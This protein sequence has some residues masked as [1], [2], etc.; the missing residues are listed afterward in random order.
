MPVTLQDIA[1]R[2]GVSVPTVSRALAGYSDIAE[3]TRARVVQA[4]EEMG[5]RPN[6]IARRLQQQR[7]ETVGFIIPTHG[8]R[9]SD[10][11][12]SELLAGIGNE[13]AEQ[14]YDLL[15]STQ[16][17]EGEEL[18]TYERMVMEQRV[19]GMLVVRTRR[20]DRRIAYLLEQEFPFVAFGRSDLDASFPYLDVDGREGM[21]Q[22][23]QHLI[24]Q[25][26][27]HIAYIGPPIH[28][29]FASHRLAGYREA[30]TANGIPFDESLVLAGE[31]TERSGHEA[32]T[33]LLAR[34]PRPDAVVACNDL[35]A[36]GT[37]SAA[38]RLGLA[39][40]HDLA[41]TGFD[42]VPLAAH[43]HPPLTTVRQPIYAIGRQICRTLI[44]L[45]RDEL[46]EHQQVVLEP[47]LIIRAS[48]T[49]V[50]ATHEGGDGHR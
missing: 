17:P 49:G 9:F 43:A 47:E 28:V 3:E 5:Y 11:F 42:D 18:K 14:E 37:I 7:T 45:L 31:L 2:L 6:V 10:P 40:G 20:Q 30:L 48:S 4:A 24:D 34:D 23:T 19:D 26:C 44:H 1:D 15:V 41:V 46:S 8:P 13:A 36:L 32:A 12:F 39:V 27:R 29:M 16:A 35:M 38:R 25:G 50:D 22:V 33:R 21:R